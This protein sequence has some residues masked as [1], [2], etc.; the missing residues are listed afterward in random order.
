[1]T[2]KTAIKNFQNVESGVGEI[3]DQKNRAPVTFGKLS[4]SLTYMYWYPRHYKKREGTEN[5]SRNNGHVFSKF[6]EN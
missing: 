1:M 3:N 5:I 4:G 6:D 2:R